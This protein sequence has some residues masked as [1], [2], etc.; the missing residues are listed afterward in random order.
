MNRPGTVILTTR[1][2]TNQIHGSVFETARNSA[3]GVARARQ[4]FYPKPPHL[5]RNEFG[6]S[7]GGPVYVPGLYNGKTRTFFFFAYEE[8]RLRQASTR[9]ISMPTAAMR[10]GDFSGLVNAQGQKFTL[11]DPMTT[12]SDGM[13]QPFFSNQIP[14]NRR[15]PLAT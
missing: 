14:I 2:G 8:F 13:R 10:E 4:D 12:D 3:I 15:S 11:Y 6:A 7:V 9:S 5:V 1:A